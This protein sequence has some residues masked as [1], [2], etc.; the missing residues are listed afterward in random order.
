MRLAERTKDPTNIVAEKVASYRFIQ[1]V[2][3]NSPPNDVAIAKKSITKKHHGSGNPSLATAF[4]IVS[5]SFRK[6]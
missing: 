5:A 3:N 4:L 6:F 2:R 1:A